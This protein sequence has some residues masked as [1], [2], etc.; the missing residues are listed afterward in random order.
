ML[1]FTGMAINKNREFCY[2]ISH[3]ENI[4]HILQNG[5]CTK[6]HPKANPDFVSIGN[7]EIIE[8]RDDMPVRIHGYGDIGEYV[9]FYFTPKSM[10]LFNIVTGYREPVVKKR[11]KQDIIVV[12]CLIKDLSKIGRFFFTDGQANEK[13][14][15]TH[16]NDLSD[17][18]RIDWN[19]IRRSDFKR[20]AADTDKT[21]RYQAEFLVYEHVPTRFIESIH[22]YNDKAATFVQKEMAKTDLLIPLHVTKEYFF[23]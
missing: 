9:P 16:Y 12:R 6:F 14:L 10:M 5:L 20:D 19:I 4:S 22:V 1:N 2:R 18:D 3:I 8:V 13:T 17:L 15:T 21:R 7:A 11:P 23:D